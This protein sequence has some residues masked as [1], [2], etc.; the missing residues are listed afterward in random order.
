MK[1]N[2]HRINKFAQNIFFFFFFLGLNS[3]IKNILWVIMDLINMFTQFREDIF[4]LQGWL[5]SATW[6]SH[7]HQPIYCAS[8]RPCTAV[9]SICLFLE[10]PDRKTIW[11]DNCEVWWHW[12][13]IEYELCLMACLEVEGGR[14]GEGWRV[15]G[16]D[17]PLPYLDVFKISKGEM[18]N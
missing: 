4:F 9:A 3:C 14:G 8:Y 18:S 13:P 11:V 2:Y 12:T 1:N 17:S 15:E 10:G 6:Q 7:W 5:A 16:N